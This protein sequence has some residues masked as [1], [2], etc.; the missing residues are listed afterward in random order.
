[1]SMAART[2]AAGNQQRLRLEQL[3]GR[4]VPATFN[5]TTPAASSV[6]NDAIFQQVDAQPTGTGFIRSFVRLQTN[7]AIEQGYNTDHRPLQFNE[8][9][10][11]QFTRSLKLGEVPVVTVD[12]VKYREFL[13]D[14]NQKST[15]T[16]SLLSLDQLRIYV[17][18]APNLSGYD[19]TTKQLAGLN[20]IF[21]MDASS[22]NSIQLNARLNSGSGSGDMT[23]LIPSSLFGSDSGKFIYLYSKFGEDKA[24]NSGFE[25]WAVRT[26]PQTD[27]PPPVNFSSLS[28]FVYNDKND[29]GILDPGEAGLVG[30]TITLNGVND[31]GQNVV[32]TAVTDSNGYYQF[33]SLRPGTYALLETQPTD[34]ADG[35]DSVGSQGGSQENDRFFDIVLAEGIDGVNNNFGELIYQES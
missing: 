28:G 15:S 31:I 9:N 4:L 20:P 17:G 18:D 12:G 22:D 1:M 29:N 27:E 23:V 13:L 6:V 7:N 25:E 21:D 26:V 2:S 34:Y 32:L 11:N 24:N 16:G 30:V 35:I 14:I 5:L 3:E 33:T 8:N 10:S 19:S